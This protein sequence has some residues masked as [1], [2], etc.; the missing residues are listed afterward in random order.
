MDYRP[1]TTKN[2]SAENLV[3]EFLSVLKGMERIK[4]LTQRQ[5]AIYQDLKAKYI[6]AKIMLD[7]ME[8]NFLYNTIEN[9]I[10]FKIGKELSIKVLEHINRIGLRL[11]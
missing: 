10:Y 1:L 2:I 7:G 9:A 11:N 5:F 6:N 4:T 3:N 8:T